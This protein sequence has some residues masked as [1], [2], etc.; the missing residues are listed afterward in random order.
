MA[1]C[2][3][4]SAAL[5]IL[6]TYFLYPLILIGLDGLRQLLGNVR[7][8]RFGGDRRKS[9]PFDLLPSVTVLIAAHN[10]ATCIAAKVSNSLAIDYPRERLEVL[11]GSDGSTDGTDEIV[12]KARDPRVVL[13]RA[14]RSGK[15]GVLNR[16]IPMASGEIVVLTDANT[17]IDPGA[18]KKLVRHFADPDVGAVCGRLRLYNPTRRGYE[19]SAYWQYESLIK[20]YEGKHGAVIGANGGLY[21]I[22]RSL[23]T[24]L[25][26][27]TIVDDFVIPLRILDRGYK[28]PYE[29]AAEATEETTEDYSK[30]FRR[31]A[32]IAA[33]NFHSL[34]LLPGLLLPTAGFA[35]F[36]LWSHKVLRWFAPGLMAL[37]LA[38]NVPLL[39]SR[40]YQ[41]TLLAQLSFYALALAGRLGV[42]RG[43]PR[44]VAS[45]AY[46]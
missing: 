9:L 34:R 6:Y 23:F 33:G 41:L 31:R 32:R 36:A 26:P 21:A 38:A 25:P 1:A 39:S 16:C 24:A 2:L 20:L 15:A 28:V 46:Y 40:L 4:W 35:A 12:R 29:P 17:M 13:A 11:V 14:E 3:F 18:V 27:S 7:Y 44:K 10:E 30:E 45:A 43:L 5:L 42:L 19:E 22:R 8:L 37:A